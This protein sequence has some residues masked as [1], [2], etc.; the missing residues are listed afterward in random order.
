MEWSSNPFHTQT[1]TTLE[2]SLF[3]SIQNVYLQIFMSIDGR[4]QDKV[5][6]YK[7]TSISE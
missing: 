2:L 6:R 3:T 1:P 4:I 7:S 5:N